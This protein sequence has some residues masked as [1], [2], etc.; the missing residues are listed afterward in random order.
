MQSS[1]YKKQ[2]IVS[3]G[4]MVIRTKHRLYPNDKSKEAPTKY[5]YEGENIFVNKS[6]KII[7]KV[8]DKK[9]LYVCCNNKNDIY[10]DFY[11]DAED[12][13]QELQS[14]L[15]LLNYSQAKQ[16][17]ENFSIDQDFIPIWVSITACQS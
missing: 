9:G 2:I 4:E 17:F 15:C 13:C 8:T 10:L 14:T 11:H 5:N 1:N 7:F 12:R 16:K 3:D 6:F